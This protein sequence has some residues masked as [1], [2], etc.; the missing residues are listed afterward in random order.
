MFFSKNKKD[1]KRREGK[2][3]REN[4]LQEIMRVKIFHYK[5]FFKF[6]LLKLSSEKRGNI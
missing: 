6:H 1:K 2:R 5:V 4:G 3:D